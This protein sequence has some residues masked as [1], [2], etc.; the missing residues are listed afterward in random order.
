MLTQAYNNKAG[1]RRRRRI[2]LITGL[3]FTAPWTVGFLIFKAY[4]VI[5]SLYYSFTE[6]NLFSAPEWTGLDNYSNLFAD[7]KFYLSLYNTV[8]LVV[9][10]LVP[11]TAFALVM[12]L[13]LNM[14]VKGQSLY[15]TIYFLPTLVPTVAASL[16]WMWLLNAKYGL[17]NDVLSL[18][19]IVGPNWLVDPS[20]T[21]PAIVFMGF[22][23]TGTATVMY[24]AA[25]QDVP[26]MFYEAAEIDGAGRWRKFW[27][28]TFPSISP[29]TLF[30]LIIGLIGTFQFFTEGMIF[31]EAAQ[32]VGGPSNSLLFYAIY[33]YQVAFSFL[34]MGYA[35]AMAWMLFIVVMVLTLL[36]FKSSAKWVYYGGEK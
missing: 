23:G 8:Y 28:I 5:M 19:G 11:Q 6:Y 31:A 27:N 15:R 35:S 26:Q 14:K 32:S 10:G 7:E 30:L 25:L 22:W 20:W 1:I 36:V 21:K 12:A 13:L 24:L 4:P 3:L 33:L 16:L 9:F 29:V 18:V 34:K 17:I 2:A